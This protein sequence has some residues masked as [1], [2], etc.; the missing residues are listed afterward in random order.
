MRCL[1]KFVEITLKFNVV[2]ANTLTRPTPKRRH[3]LD[4]K[5]KMDGEG[6]VPNF[7]VLYYFME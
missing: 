1:S 6:L 3:A 4:S 5:G 7:K 2:L